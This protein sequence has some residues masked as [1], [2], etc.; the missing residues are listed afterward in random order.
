MQHIVV[1]VNGTEHSDGQVPAHENALDWLR[2]RGFTGAKE[3]CAEGECGACSVLVAAP[4]D[5][6][7]TAWTA[8][9]SCLVPVA[10]LDGRWGWAA[11]SGWAF[12][13]LFG[14][15]LAYTYYMVLVRDW[16]ASRA[17][18]Y[19]FISPVI[20]VALGVAILGEEVRISDMIGMAVMLLAAWQALREKEVG[21]NKLTRLEVVETMH[22]R[23]ARM[24]ELSDGFIAMSGG[25]GTFE[26]I[27][28]I[29][30]WSQLG[31][32]G[33]PLGFL[34]IDGFYDALA[35]FLDNTTKAGFMW[36]AHRDM[37]MMETDPA[38]LLDKMEAY[39]PQ[40]QIKW[41]EKTEV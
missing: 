24:A 14:S 5:D 7:G 31:I 36:Q 30:T 16:G 23:K 33:K 39:K 21:H 38:A 8:V 40:T 1:T 34:N 4:G 6:G 15:L 13:V 17:G 26:E 37:A 20:A 10:A 11:W 35:A 29:W 2:S 18:T 9:N 41:V 19:A 32:H 25:I 12:L 27:F 22:I 3:G 28:E